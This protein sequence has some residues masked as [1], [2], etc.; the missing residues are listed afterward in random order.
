MRIIGGMHKGRV[1]QIPAKLPVRPTTDFA[2]EAVFNIIQNQFDIPN[3]S[4]LDLFAG[5]GAI[6]LE[7]ASRG[8]TDITAVDNH[9]GCIQFIQKTAQSWNLKGLKAIKE[10]VFRY[11]EKSTTNYHIVFADPPYAL[12]N[13]SD[14]PDMLFKKKLV[15]PEG[16]LILEHGQEHSFEN[17]PFF[18]QHRRYGNVN[19]S[20]FQPQTS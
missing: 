20:I 10:D 15:H 3:I 7:M 14:L 8:C 13:L 17:H 11:I 12:P 18:I 9:R 5:T 6:S 16:W 1:L 2:R 4:L 19:F